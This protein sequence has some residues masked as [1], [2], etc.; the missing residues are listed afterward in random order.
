MRNIHSYYCSFNFNCHSNSLLVCVEHIN[1]MENFTPVTLAMAASDRQLPN[2]GAHNKPSQPMQFDF[3][4]REFEKT[5]IV[6]KEF[7]SLW[8]GNWRQLHYDCSRDLAFCHTRVIAF[9]MGKL[10]LSMGNVKDTMQ[11]FSFYGLQYWKDVTVAFG[12]HEKSATHKRAVKGV[13]TLPQTTRDVHQLMLKRNVRL[14]VPH[15]HC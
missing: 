13:I 14:T 11:S 9:K 4:K 15:Y 5:R 12:S 2:L 7:Q 10:R 1:C 3:L 6:K 8:F